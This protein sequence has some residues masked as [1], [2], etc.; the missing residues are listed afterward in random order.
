MKKLVLIL[1]VVASLAL[2]VAQGAV[3]DSIDVEID[4][5]PRCERNI[6]STKAQGL[7]LVAILGSNNLAVPDVDVATLTFGPNEASPV[8]D[9]SQPLALAHHLQDI[10]GDTFT[11]LVLHFNVQDTGIADGNIEAC[12]QGATI[13]GATF[14]P[15]D[16]I[17]VK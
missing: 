12:L 2:V 17:V 13:D 14:E 7:L 15:C 5:K 11:D 6:I 4:I 9:L 3:A 10:N 16:S 8:H 1:A